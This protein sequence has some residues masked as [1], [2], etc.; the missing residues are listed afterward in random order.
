MMMS[1][2]F[3]PYFVYLKD[4]FESFLVSI[5]FSYQIIDVVLCLDN[6]PGSKFTEPRIRFRRR[7]WLWEYLYL[8]LLKVNLF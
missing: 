1:D 4:M 8:H 6:A 2:Y 3:K 7:S 5:L